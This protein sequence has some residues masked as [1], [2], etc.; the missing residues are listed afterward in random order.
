MRFRVFFCVL[1]GFCV[2]LHVFLLLGCPWAL[3]ER[4]WPLLGHSWAALGALLGRSW[5]LSG[6]FGALLRRSWSALGRSWDAL[7]QKY[8]KK[9]RGG[10]EIEV[11]LGGVLEGFWPS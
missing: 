8:E 11:F 6:A 10:C 2:F 5:A 9:S 7:G 4:S 1:M 3:L